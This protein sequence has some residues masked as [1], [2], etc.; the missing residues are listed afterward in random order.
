MLIGQS[1][2]NAGLAIALDRKLTEQNRPHTIGNRYWGGYAIE[3]WM[4][5][6][7]TR[8]ALYE[9]T[10]EAFTI[11]VDKALRA[12]KPIAFFSVIWFQGEADVYPMRYP[13]YESRLRP[14]LAALRQTVRTQWPTMPEVVF[15]ISKPYDKE[16]QF[17]T[18]IESIGR[19]IDNVALDP[20]MKACAFETRDIPRIDTVH[21]DNNL[22]VG[23]VDQWRVAERAIACARRAARRC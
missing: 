16:A 18:A 7:G 21:I 19:A 17:Q 6:D 4:L 20:A 11:A 5:E 14:L 12:G 8:G 1:N 2:A 10:I 3:S 15:S 9:P 22:D 13:S 23:S